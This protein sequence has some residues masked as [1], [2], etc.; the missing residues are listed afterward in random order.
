MFQPSHGWCPSAEGLAH[1]RMGQ[2]NHGHRRPR[3]GR[4]SRGC[5]VAL[6]YNLYVKGTYF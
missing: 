1:P 6:H 2:P 3:L 4:P 5:K